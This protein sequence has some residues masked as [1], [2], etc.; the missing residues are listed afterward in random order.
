[1]G[2][3]LGDGDPHEELVPRVE[4]EEAP[5]EAAVA[6]VPSAG[7]CV[8]GLE[9]DARGGRVQDAVSL[10]VAAG[11]SGVGLVIALEAVEQDLAVDEVEACCLHED[12]VVVELE[13]RA[14]VRT[15]AL[16]RRLPLLYRRVFPAC[17]GACQ[18][19][20]IVRWVR[21]LMHFI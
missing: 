7:S 11:Q 2:D 8:S 3:Q 15:G 18:D 13:A 5:D 19:R 20:E 17:Q 16:C 21:F 14:H 10:D 1:M 12:L 9:Q 4:E 6:V